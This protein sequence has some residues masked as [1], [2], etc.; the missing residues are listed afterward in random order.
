MNQRKPIALFATTAIALLLAVFVVA[1]VVLPAN[2]AASP[3]PASSNVSLLKHLGGESRAVDVAGSFAYIGV[4]PR[5]TIVNIANPLLPSLRSQTVP[6][7]DVI[8]SLVYASPYV[9]L[10][11]GDGGLHIYNVSDV[12][13]PVELG[14]A[15][16]PG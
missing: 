1:S 5:L 3:P 13:K 11:N 7:S 8:E 10:V 6:L 14:K 16:T 15:N 2:A 9:Y 12:N 4:G